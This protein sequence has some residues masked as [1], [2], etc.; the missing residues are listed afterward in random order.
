MSSHIQG[1]DFDQSYSPMVHSES[2]RINISIVDM[3]R[4]SDRFLD[5][6]NDFHYTNVP[7]RER[8]SRYNQN[9]H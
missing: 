5:V 8:V 2:F 3:H 6:S 4:L 9:Q 1:V 7:I